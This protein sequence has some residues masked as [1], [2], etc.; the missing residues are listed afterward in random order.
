MGFFTGASIWVEGAASGSG[1]R[2]A[3]LGKGMR[4]LEADDAALVAGNGVEREG[5][6]TE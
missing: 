6:K 4:I 1:V 3:V 2:A 5:A